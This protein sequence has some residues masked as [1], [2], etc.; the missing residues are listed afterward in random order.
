MVHLTLMLRI[1]FM[2][3]TASIHPAS[4]NLTREKG[5]SVAN[6]RLGRMSLVMY[7]SL[8][9]AMVLAAAQTD[10][11]QQ[12]QKSPTPLQTDSTVDQIAGRLERDLPV[13]MKAADVPGL[14]IAL[15]RNGNVAWVRAFGVKDSKS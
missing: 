2:K 12:P 1:L 14:S 3:Q 8:A 15:I 9:L 7:G 10:R 5:K 4:F 6:V 11:S 13:L